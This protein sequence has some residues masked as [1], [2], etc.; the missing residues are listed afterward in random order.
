M[1][2]L[3]NPR[4]ERFAQGLAKG[5]TQIEAYTTAG[6]K[7]HDSAAARLCGNVRIQARVAEL[8]S[9]GAQE[10]ETTVERLLRAGWDI[11][12]EAKA[13]Q[14]FSAASQT[15]E[16]VAKIAGK[17]V[18]KSA[19]A[20]VPIEDLLDAVDARSDRGAAATSH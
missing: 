14:D 20:T 2:P 8:Q 9:A 3:D 16:R 12:T 7:P 6:F 13:A 10:A 19:T 1:P 11:L 17:W 5:Q 4:H 15:L 18:D